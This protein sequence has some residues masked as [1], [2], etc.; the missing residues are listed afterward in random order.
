MKKLIIIFSFISTVLSAQSYIPENFKF[1]YDTE[2]YS[3]YFDSTSIVKNGDTLKYKYMNIPKRNYSPGL[4]CETG[5]FYIICNGEGLKLAFQYSIKYYYTFYNITKRKYGNNP[6]IFY[7]HDKSY[8]ETR[9]FFD[10]HRF[11]FCE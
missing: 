11:K 2:Y 7:S 4:I 9:L 8:I 6:L 5:T 1:Y 3:Y 10:F